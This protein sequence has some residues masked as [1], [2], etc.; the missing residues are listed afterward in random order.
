MIIGVTELRRLGL[1]R[2]PAI[3]VPNHMLEQ[4]A[5]EWLQL[6]P[7]QGAGRPPRGVPR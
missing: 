7:V 1:T 3:V 2:K 5:R 6:S 4:F